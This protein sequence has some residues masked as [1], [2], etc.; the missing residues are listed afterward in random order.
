MSL[1]TAHVSSAPGQMLRVSVSERSELGTRLGE[2]GLQSRAPVLVLISGADGVDAETAGHLEH[3]FTHAIA[4]IADALGAYVVDGGTDAGVMGLMGRA[5]AAIGARFPLV[6][7]VPRGRL[8]ALPA[9]GRAARLEP[10]HSHVV[11]VPGARWEDARPWLSWV[12]E[13][14][15]GGLPSVTLLVNGGDMAWDDALQSIQD[16]RPLIAVAGS[17]RAADALAAALV[18]D[19]WEPRAREVLASGMVEAVSIADGPAILGRLLG[20]HLTAPPPAVEREQTVEG[21]DSLE[22]RDLEGLIDSLELPA[23][24]KHFLRSRWLDQVMWMNGRARQAQ[25]RY[26]ALRMVVIAG[27][28]AIPVMLGLPDGGATLRVLAAI[29]AML[30]ALST[31]IEAFFH[32]G[33]RWQHYRRTV[34][35]LKTEGWRFFQRTGP[36]RRFRSHAAAYAEFAGTVER[37]LEEDVNVYIDQIARERSDKREP[38]QGAKAQPDAVAPEPA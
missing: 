21:D 12:A 15:A 4:P 28:I 26:Y 19:G 20:T 31:A 36:Y 6:G 17:G 37:L 25:S 3:L 13:E 10:H 38:A 32:Y 7:V 35:R 29:A 16:G 18:G 5:R 2:I 23:L 33:E 30:V 34:E 11:L 8:D 9:M 24:Q 14:L 1:A 27:S 22:R